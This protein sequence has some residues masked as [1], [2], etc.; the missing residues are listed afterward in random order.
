M[1]PPA[2]LLLPV[3]GLL[4]N[5]GA[6]L[7]REGFYGSLLP[8]NL[9]G[10]YNAFMAAAAAGCKRIV[11][12]SSVNAV[13]GYVGNNEEGVNPGGGWGGGPPQYTPGQEQY[14]AD[15]TGEGSGNAWDAPV[16]PVNVYGASRDAPPTIPAPPNR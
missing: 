7:G 6:L 4:T 8:L 12:A 13:L 14:H 5:G 16:W 2:L 15:G 11:F 3:R 10:C 9:I 1:R